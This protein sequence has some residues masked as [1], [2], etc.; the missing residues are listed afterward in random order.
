MAAISF[1]MP[2]LSRKSVILEAD[3]VRILDRR[4]FPLKVSFVDCQTVEEV[5]LAI[6]Q[7]VTQS[8][9]PSLAASAGM[10]LAARQ[11]QDHKG[12]ERLSRM[13]A[14]ATRLIATRHTNNMIANAVGAMLALAQERLDDDAFAD[15]LEAGMYELWQASRARSRR[16][17]EHSGNLI[18]DGDTILTHCWGESG[19]IEVLATALRGGKRPKVICSETRPYLQGSRL[20]AHSVAE[21][22]IDVTVITD[23]MGAW[24]M[25]RGMVTKYITAADRVTMSGHVVNKVG[26]LQ[27]AL[28]AQA[29]HIPYYATVQIPDPKAH[30]P[31]DV[32]MEDRD[33]DESL[34]CMGMR[35]ASPLARGWYPA[36]DITPPHLVT[37]IITSK[38][39]FAPDQLARFHTG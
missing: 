24:A 2:T 7:M 20:T 11:A 17:G 39:V 33:P 10:V 35:T 34:A 5:A 25:D 38:G 18:E 14:A 27:L 22:G 36:F 15:A 13:Q 31:E 26:T 3:R 37:A 19:I 30:G 32:P 1:E 9:G 29:Y 4:V 23:N 12:A 21:M 16:L 8:G 6:E 28:S